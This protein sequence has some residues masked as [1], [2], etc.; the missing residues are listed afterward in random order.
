MKLWNPKEKKEKKKIVGKPHL[1]RQVEVAQKKKNSNNKKKMWAIL[2]KYFCP[3]FTLIFSPIWRDCVLEGRRENWWVPPKSLIFSTLNQTTK[4]IIF[5]PLFSPS[6]SI[7]PK[8]TPTKHSLRGGLYCGWDITQKKKK[9][10][11]QITL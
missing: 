6:F 11:T 5:S 4:N 9:K 8:I 10:I 2:S 1:L 3:T 7:L